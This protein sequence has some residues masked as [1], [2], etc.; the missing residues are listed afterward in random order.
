MTC[1]ENAGKTKGIFDCNVFAKR[2]LSAESCNYL[3]RFL[4]TMSL[5]QHHSLLLNT[6]IEKTPT[7]FRVALEREGNP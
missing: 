1:G 5:K 4:V 6:D 7:Y 3:C 2:V